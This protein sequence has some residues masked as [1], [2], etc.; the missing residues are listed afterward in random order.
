M[1]NA[2]RPTLITMRILIISDIHA[3]LTA[4]ETVVKAAGKVDAVWCLGDLVGYGD[5]IQMSA[6]IYCAHCLS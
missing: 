4:F 5:L 1:G 3:N 6:S 2:V